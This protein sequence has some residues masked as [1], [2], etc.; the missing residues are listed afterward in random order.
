MSFRGIV[1]WASNVL[2][3]VGD[4]VGTATKIV[5]PA[6][7]LADGHVKNQPAGAQWEN[8]LKHETARRLNAVNMSL[9]RQLRQP[10]ADQT[11][12][13]SVV[14]RYRNEITYRVAAA[15]TNAITHFFDDG[16]L[17]SPSVSPASGVWTPRSIAASTDFG[18]LAVGQNDTT[19]LGFWYAAPGDGSFSEIDP[20]GTA[21]NWTHVTVDAVDGSI[22]AQ[23]SGVSTTQ[24]REMLTVDP[25]FAATS[26]GDPDGKNGAV[27]DGV[28]AFPSASGSQVIYSLNRGVDWLTI[29]PSLG[30]IQS[31]DY[32]VSH[33]TWVLFA[34]DSGD[35]IVYGAASPAGPWTELFRVTSTYS[36]AQQLDGVTLIQTDVGHAPN[37]NVVNWRLLVSDDLFATA[38]KALYVLEHVACDGAFVYTS[39]D[40]ETLHLKGGLFTE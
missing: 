35:I 4:D 32:S 19:D 27:H 36:Y 20:G 1:N 24:W 15:D 6:G 39:N 31:I 34:T 28:I 2:Y 5:P 21:A 22:W 30:T 9:L 7:I 33:E 8:Y 40:G 23:G 3:S 13:G 26:Y 38:P 12:L 11:A 17:V 16:R 14:A 25:T 37:V 18:V 29:S 10:S